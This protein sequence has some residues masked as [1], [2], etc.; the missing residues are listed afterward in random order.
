MIKKSFRFIPA[1]VFSLLIIIMSHQPQPP[2]MELGFEWQDK[3]MH[4][5]AY[6]VYGL[7]LLYA[8]RNNTHVILYTLLIGMAFGAS[9]EIHQYFVPSRSAEFLDWFA[10]CGGIIIAVLLFLLIR[11][12]IRTRNDI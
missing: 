12:R 3:I 8:F 2:H 4:L 10:D 6:T 7:L 1:I 11:K 9:D 5:G